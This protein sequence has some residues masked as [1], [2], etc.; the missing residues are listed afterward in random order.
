M[1][2]KRRHFFNPAFIFFLLVVA[3]WHPSLAQ[4]DLTA[5]VRPNIGSA[6][7][8]YFFYTPAAVPF[9]M[10][11]LGPSTDGT[12]GNKS[13]WEAVGYDDRHASIEGFANFHEFQIGGLLLA[14][15][16]GTLQTAPGSS[17]DPG[18]GF[19]SRFDKKDELATAG[20]YRVR[21]KDYHV[22]A[23]L[24][25]TQRV[26]F[27]RYTFPANDT[28][29]L[30]FDVGHQ[31]G[32]SGPVVD[33]QVTY[34]DGNI[35]GFIETNPVYVNK[36]QHGATVKMYFYAHLDQ[37]P[38]AV[39]TFNDQGIYADQRK[40][41]GKGSGLYLR[42]FN[43]QP[44]AIEVKIGLSY[45]SIANAQYNLTAEAQDVN[46]DQA[47]KKAN[48]TWNQYL[49]RIQV[50]GGSETD[51]IKFY[52][53]LYHALLGRGLASD[54]NG[55]YPKNDGK[56]GRIPT[57]VNGKPK[58]Q[59]YNTD[60]IWGAFWNLT[61]LWALVYPEY[62]NDWIQSQLLVYKDAG[63]L[64][65]GIANSR[66]V[67]GVGT[68]FTGLAIAAA[69]NV[70]IR[71]YDVALAYD[72]VRKNELTSKDRRLGAGKMDV[73]VFVERGY[74]P[75][76]EDTTG[77]PELMTAGSPFGASHTLEYAF[78]ASAAE[79]FAKALGKNNDANLFKRLARGWE[80]LY[81]DETQFIRPRDSSGKFLASFDPYQPWRGF[82]E[83]N[84]WQYTFY[85]P[86]QIERLVEKIGK[87]KFNHRLDSVFRE[88]RKN[89]F[90]GGTQIDAFAGINSL[91]N[92]GN[93]PNLH[94][95]WLFHFSG[96]P[97]LTHYWVRA[98]CNE[99][100]G[101]D[102]IH[103]YGYGQDEDQGQLGAWYV[104]SALGL[105]DVKALTSEKPSFQIGIP[106][107]D[108]ILI[109]Q[110]IS[111]GGKTIEI[112][113]S[114]PPS[115]VGANAKPTWNHLKLTS[116]SIPFQDLMKGGQLRIQ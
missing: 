86:H 92:H 23:E 13:G 106:L 24:T 105:F 94:I 18:T 83:G 12:T 54:A 99:F 89:I 101:L 80:L 103:G 58:H 45:T 49:N 75:F 84:A 65:D 55:F 14:A 97:D 61:Q 107:F 5:L 112:L 11:K 88:A 82:Q 26:G 35:F 19:R 39:G 78:A 20:Y 15:T 37:S 25:A 90:G 85:V 44:L 27:H 87:Q 57:D 96:R 110:P 72:A 43:S 68:N 100:Y 21:L 36:Y 104:M 46:F 10:A 29:Q 74:S 69:Y 40:Q 109:H 81:D 66:Y 56:V 76:Q 63:W 60:A 32:E 41:S 4:N 51:R 2:N 7:S 48:Q 67:S 116:W 59:H 79:V 47:K 28:A 102:G 42:Y 114:S 8:R 64:G 22:L 9:G 34:Q 50:S 108:R 91:Y 17:E 95:S 38:Q 73:G 30:I 6:H 111:R 1:I 71:D 62:Y 52:T 77:L 3:L 113:N 53:G 70:G 115:K 98:I 16:T 93:Q 31:L 33:A